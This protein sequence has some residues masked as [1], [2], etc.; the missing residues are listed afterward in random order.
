M[1]PKE[2]V[3]AW[4]KAFNAGDAD[5]IGEFYVDEAVNHQ[6]ANAPIKGKYAIVEMFASEFSQA[7]MTCIVE[8]IFEDGEWAI[9]EWKDPNGLRGCGFSEVQNTV[10]LSC[11]PGLLARANGKTSLDLVACPQLVAFERG[12]ICPKEDL[13]WREVIGIVHRR[14]MDRPK[15]GRRR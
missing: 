10:H 6:V 4:V 5:A 7:E 13:Q 2:L 11:Q 3:S 1:R 14:G 15:V 9:L 8:N 12:D